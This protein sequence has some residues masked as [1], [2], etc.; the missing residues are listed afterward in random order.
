MGQR[1]GVGRRQE[2][3]CDAA[4]PSRRGNLARLAWLPIPLF[5]VALVGLRVADL[6]A[7]YESVGLLLA[8]NLVFSVLV[9]LFIAYLIGRSFLVR[10]TPGLLLLGCGVLMWG[11]AGFVGVVAGLVAAGGRLDTNVLIAVHNTSAW[12]AGLCHLVGVGMSLRPRRP[13]RSAGLWLAS[14]YAL[15]LGAVALIV[16]AAL[17]G[18]MPV[19]FVQGQGGTL[20][21]DLVL[22]S[23]AGVFALTALVL[24][25]ANRRSASAFA[26]WYSLALGLIAVGLFGIMIEPVHGGFL[27][28]TGRAPQ[29]LSGVYLLAAA[30]AS[31]RETHAW[32]IPLEAALR[33]RARSQRRDSV[34]RRR[35][36]HR[37][38]SGGA[39]RPLQPRLRETHRLRPG[40]GRRPT[41]LGLPPPGG[42]ARG[43]AGDLRRP[44]RRQLAERVREPLGGEGR[45]TPSPPLVQHRVERRRWERRVHHR[46][47]DRHHR[48][49]AGRGGAAGER[50][51]ADRRAGEHA[52]RLRELRCRHALHVRQRQRG[53]VFKPRVA[54]SFSARTCGSS[55]R[56]RNPTRPSVS[57][58]GRSGSRDP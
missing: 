20:L 30:L 47:R 16:A 19:F 14:G 42:G 8:L 39:R 58:S 2:R 13:L 1:T 31:V 40:G 25:L 24:Q 37:P 51:E 32:R 52:R 46:H 5:V 21:R 27:S 56:I 43:G 48:A 54:R 18:R 22:G 10:A 36:R 4:S 28:W 12:L 23:A 3:V 15:A 34:H 11:A 55:T 6:R 44:A 50:A 35:P 7:Q 26:Y 49:Q 38:R 41:L 9:C 45:G 17:A 53:D 57:T 29:F 33:H